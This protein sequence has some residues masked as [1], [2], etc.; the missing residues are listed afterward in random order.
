MFSNFFINSFNDNINL[1]E[2]SKMKEETNWFQK[3]FVRLTTR[4]GGKSILQNGCCLLIFVI[5]IFIFIL[6]ILIGLGG[7]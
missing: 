4:D 7:K 6:G 5:T 1:M 3:E 2:V